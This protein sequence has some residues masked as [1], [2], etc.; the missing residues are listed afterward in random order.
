MGDGD[1]D[2]EGEGEGL[3]EGDGWLSAVCEVA[4]VGDRSRERQKAASAKRR[5]RAN[6]DAMMRG[7]ELLRRSCRGLTQK[8]AAS[9]H[10][11]AAKP[12]PEVSAPFHPCFELI[13]GNVT[14]A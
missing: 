11:K 8:D 10:W 2:G 1:G 3:G 13:L 12:L 7:L 6:C 9:P 14:E 5:M 4:G